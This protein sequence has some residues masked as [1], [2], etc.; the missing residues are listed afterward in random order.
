[1]GAYAGVAMATDIELLENVPLDYSGYVRRQHRWIRGDWQ[2]APWIF[3]KVPAPG[4]TVR[5]PLRIIHR[6]R[7]LDNLRRSLVP[8]ASLLLLLIGWLI[9]RVPGIS[10]LVVA[11]A[12][13]TPALAPLLDRWARQ[14]H[15][16]V[17]GWRGAADELLRAGLMVA[18]L[19]HQAWISADAIVRA[20][21][22]SHISKRHMLEWQ[23]ADAAEAHAHHHRNTTQNQMLVVS[24]A[25]LFLTALILIRGAFAPSAGFLVLWALSPLL[26]RWFSNPA[27]V[28]ASQQ[29][30]PRQVTYLRGQARRTWR[31][32]DDLVGPDTNWLPP[33][34]SQLA[35]RVEV[36]HRTSP[37][38]I[39]M[40]LTA[41][42]AARDFGYL[43]ADDLCRRCSATLATM[44]QLERYEGHLLNWYNTTTR[45]PLTP[46]Y[47]SSVDS[48]NLLASL[49]VLEQGCREVVRAP[50]VGTESLRA[51]ADT[52]AI[53]AHVSGEDP[54]LSVPLR[55]I[56]RLL[57][58][59]LAQHEFIARLRMTA[60]AA[61]Q[62]QEVRQWQTAPT[63]EPAYWASSLAREA[64]SW[65]ATVNRYLLWMETLSRPPNSFLHSL[66]EELV[67]LRRQA[68]ET[69]PSLHAL[70]ETGSAPTETIL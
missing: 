36:A 21:Y 68:V 56:R 63:D 24:A 2:I 13:V 64:A 20:W 42:L 52:A 14:L 10:S 55:A 48:G 45:E 31:Y 17:S 29:I 23:T 44:E 46:K 8:V 59:D 22:R 18:F 40:W 70:A 61:A 25:S 67:D 65:S 4:G 39:G 66:G 62:L 30:S 37:T 35:L 60:H 15:G 3:P 26:L 1:E 27:R 47:V 54:S 41:A 16:S 50:L 6:W 28:P 53:L 34:N 38:N 51:L 57:R 69:I 7:I 43:T 32:F 9:S 58:G 49:W 19:P 12:V 5:N 11:L 33:D